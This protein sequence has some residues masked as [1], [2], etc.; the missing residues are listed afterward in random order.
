M[1]LTPTWRRSWR[2]A[3][4]LLLVSVCALLVLAVSARA[5]GPARIRIAGRSAI[6]AGAQA[7]GVLPQSTTIHATV[8]LQPRDPAALAAYA[9]AVS[10]PGSGLYHRYLTVGQ[11]THRFGA[12]PSQVAALRF[13]LRAAGLQLG[14]L[15]A[16]GL[17]FSVAPP[18]RHS[19]ACSR[20]RSSATGCQA[21]GSALPT[22]PRVAAGD[23][24]HPGAGGSRTSWAGLGAGRGLV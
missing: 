20:P 11:F 7:V 6:P 21:V 22:Q 13:S 18:R 17:S 5:A 14:P 2:P 1:A 16:N 12:T 9:A 8:A 19:P 10:T 15:A 4:L 24:R 3:L 23:H